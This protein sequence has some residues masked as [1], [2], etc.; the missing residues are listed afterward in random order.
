MTAAR[1]KSIV[2]RIER[3]NGKIDER[4]QDKADIF[5][6]AKSDGYD[7]PALKALIAER[8]KQAKDPVKFDELAA[9][10]ETYRA[11]LESGTGVATRAGAREVASNVVQ[12]GAA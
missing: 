5:K 12:M 6:E 9:M 10:V 1:L 7:V 4:N 8:R 11:A 2:D 3:I